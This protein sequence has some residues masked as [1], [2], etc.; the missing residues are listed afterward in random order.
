[1]TIKRV[2]IR[3]FGCLSQKELAFHSG[4][5]VLAEPN[6][7]GKSTVA[8]FIRV[9]L[10]GISTPRF[11]QRKKYMPFHE[12]SMGGA[13][14]V[15]QDGRTYQIERSFG[16]KKS[17]D[18]IRVT[19]AVSG[20][21][22]EELAV[23]QVGRALCGMGAEA[24]ENSLYI[25]QLSC[26][27]Q[28][29]KSEELQ[30][31]LM[32]L[33]QSGDENYSYANA[34]RILN[35]AIRAL[36]GGRGKIAVLQDEISAHN[37]RRQAH[38]AASEQMRTCRQQLETLEQE[39]QNAPAARSI[40]FRILALAT[41]AALLCVSA[42][43]FINSQWRNYALCAAVL[44]GLAAYGCSKI[45]VKKPARSA[46]AAA[47]RI[48][49][50]Q[51]Q[52]RQLQEVCDEYDADAL[53]QCVERLRHYQ[54]MLDELQYARQALTE[55]FEQLQRD[56]TPRLNSAAAEILCR[57]TN[58]RYTG[59]LADGLGEITV[60]TADGQL[61]QGAYLS[62]GTFDQIYFAL[63]MAII[64]LLAPDMPVLLDDAFAQYDDERLAGALEYLKTMPNQILLLSCQQREK[65]L[66]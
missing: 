5:N 9:M 1:M 61:I 26:K 41:A 60:R 18:T 13:L 38:R 25:K 50:L 35:D 43:F 64:Q 3:R 45:E 14:T 10:Y 20:R 59:F 19:D 36:N 40:W 4:L 17:E 34:Q 65:N 33:T 47:Q 62:G 44:L 46:L 54:H 29:E 7:W 56:Y 28:A 27:V 48:G 53:Q 11:N 21:E 58:G 15:E 31:K 63:R 66:L 57:I 51:Q 49:M 8:E 6:E 22:L 2:Y 12:T 55:A 52:L 23:E 39:Q 37:H 42:L 16:L 32:N 30:T 24:F